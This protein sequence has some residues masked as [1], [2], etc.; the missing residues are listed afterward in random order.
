MENLTLK[1][2]TK[3]L[4]IV[5]GKIVYTLDGQ[6]QFCWDFENALYVEYKNQIWE[7]MGQA[8]STGN[9]VDWSYFILELKK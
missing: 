1:V 7:V 2:N 4:S 3:D 8:W 5:E 6:I 9:G